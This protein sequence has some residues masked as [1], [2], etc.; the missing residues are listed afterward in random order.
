MHDQ[1]LLKISREEEKFEM[2][3]ASPINFQ[4]AL[5]LP[6]ISLKQ[7]GGVVSPSSFNKRKDGFASPSNF[8]MD[9]TPSGEQ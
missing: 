3:A 2:E 1:K 8:L 6:N 4:E 5:R 9:S 7:T